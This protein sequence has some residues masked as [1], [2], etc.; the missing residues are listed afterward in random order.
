MTYANGTENF[1]ILTQQKFKHTFDFL[2]TL[3]TNTKL[4][5]KSKR[6]KRGLINAV[7]KV[8]KW[9]FGTLDSDDEE[10][11]NKY[12]DNLLQNQQNVQQELEKEHT[13]LTSVINSYTEHL[14]KLGDNQKLILN[15][16]NLLENSQLDI[17]S[18]LYL[19]L[20]LDNI[21]FQLNTLNQ[22]INN[23]ENA[24]SFAHVNTMHN[25]IL[26]PNQLQ[27]MTNN[28]RKLYGSDRLP[29]F[30]ELINYYKYLSAQ[31]ITKNN[32][33]LFSI[34]TPI[35]LPKKFT[36]YKILPIPIL[37]QT[38]SV[39]NPFI[40]LTKEEFWTTTEECP[41]LE[42]C[43]ICQQTSLSKE[44]ACL[45][46]L[47]I[48]TKNECPLT[49][50]NYRKTSIQRLNGEE[51]LVIPYNETIIR[52]TCQK[53]IYNII[54]PSLLT[55]PTCPIEINNQ[56]YEKDKKTEFQFIL[57]L[58]KFSYADTKE[59]SSKLQLEEVNLDELNKAQKMLSSIQFHALNTTGAINHWVTP[60]ATIM[61]IAIG[62]AIY[63]T[64]NKWSRRTSTVSQ[65][66]S[67]TNSTQLQEPINRKTSSPLFSELKEGGDM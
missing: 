11:F 42:E 39:S 59:E 66:E 2:Q 57:D 55:I 53:G 19:S 22:L 36:L 8:N 45:F 26:N 27:K 40:L 15:K 46:K 54:K 10:K 23:I 41:Q 16:L 31:V 56:V 64:R 58:P 49:N 52:S 67:T 12:F 9:L 43:S 51:I 25:S 63:V 29:K 18:A 1:A 6:S 33:I 3:L 30:N 21:M 17:S 38:I 35:I 4:F 20:I 48:T 60:L 44:E 47:L 65:T 14:Q 62:L 34:H 13:V 24:I 61:F 32:I 37:N 28:I 50:I 5:H 7:G